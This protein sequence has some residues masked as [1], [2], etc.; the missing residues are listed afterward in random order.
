MCPRATGRAVPRSFELRW[1]RGQITEEATVSTRY[2]A[3]AIQLLEFEDPLLLLSTTP[4]L[5]PGACRK[6]L[7]KVRTK[8]VL[9]REPA[10]APSHIRAG[11]TLGGHLSRPA[12]CRLH[13]ADDTPETARHLI[14]ALSHIRRRI[15]AILGTSETTDRRISGS[16][17]SDC[18]SLPS[19]SAHGR[20]EF[21]RGIG[22]TRRQFRQRRRRFLPSPEVRSSRAEKF[23]GER[24]DAPVAAAGAARLHACASS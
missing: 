9:S 14:G 24:G 18:D 19:V 11:L 10:T 17:G 22:G 3:P 7:S 15:L 6:G 20:L 2:H 23:D 5:K 4:R 16:S 1:G 12:R 8:R 21:H 13:I